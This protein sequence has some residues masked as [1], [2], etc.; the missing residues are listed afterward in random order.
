MKTPITQNNF[1]V[2]YH[3]HNGV[4]SPQL[5]TT[6]ATGFQSTVRAYLA[7]PSQSIA[8]TVY[9]KIQLNAVDF[10]LLSEYDMT[11]YRF[12]AAATGYYEVTGSI[13]WTTVIGLAFYSV[14]IFKN[15]NLI[16]TGGALGQ[17]AFDVISSVTDLVQLNAGE[18][19]ELFAFQDAGTDQTVQGSPTPGTFFSIKRVL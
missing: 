14:R 8:T 4:D 2:P 5:T 13:Y 17:R 9:V 7:T 15:G 11:T 10:D 18:Y 1:V 12:T 6:V 3:V 16:S 19:L